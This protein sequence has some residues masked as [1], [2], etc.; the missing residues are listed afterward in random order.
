M[1]NYIAILGARGVHHRAS[2][3]KAKQGQGNTLK[4]KP[5]IIKV[6]D[7]KYYE[8]V[9]QGMRQV[10]TSSEST[11]SKVF[12]K[13][14][15]PVAAKT[16]TAEKSGKVNPESEVDYI[17]SHLGQIAPSLSWG[18]V[19]KEMKRLM[20]KY[21]NLY[22]TEDS[23]VRR[24]VIN[25]T[26]GKVD[27]E[28]IDEHKS[29]YDPFAWVVA[30]APADNPKIAVCAMVPQGTTAANAAPIIKEVI[31]KYFDTK[32]KYTNYKTEMIVE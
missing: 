2:V 32:A 16:G 26:N 9:I 5:E 21:P 19:K 4:S 29:K 31:S 1:A 8:Y 18:P 6:D 10:A 30:L 25:L 15:I 11:V 3:I 22:L 27:G 17:K 28:K 12:G 13:M 7:K 23:A 14:K 20:K 24:A